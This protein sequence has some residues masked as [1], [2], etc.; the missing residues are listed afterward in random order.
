MKILH[1]SINSKFLIH[2]DVIFQKAFPNQNHYLILEPLTK[3]NT[4]S[5]L[6]KLPNLEKSSFHY[7]NYFFGKKELSKFDLIFF[8]GFHYWFAR[9]CIKHKEFKFYLIGWG[10]EIYQNPMIFNNRFLEKRDNN[11]IRFLKSINYSIPINENYQHLTVKRGFKYLYK[12]A[13]LPLEFDFL[14]KKKLINKTC[15]L[16]NF[17]YYVID[18]FFKKIKLDKLGDGIVVGKSAKKEENH[19]KVFKLLNKNKVTNTLYIPS[20]TGDLRNYKKTLI[21]QSKI[22]K[23]DVIFLSKYMALEDFIK[24]IQKSNT[25][26]MANERQ[27]GLGTIL[28]SIY[29]GLNVFLNSKNPIYNYLKDMNLNIYTLESLK[30]FRTIE[31]NDTKIINLNRTIL[32]KNFSVHNISKELIYS[33]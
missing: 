24:S 31:V 21:E 14:K 12:V 6:N 10:G 1:I 33:I 5:D 22:Y 15:K 29:L 7:F 26:V 8:H 17:K 27:L 4:F 9:K 32:L 25:L 2:S 28:I 23:G 11:L 16:F 19:L 13:Y 20:S 18:H 3:K 30:N